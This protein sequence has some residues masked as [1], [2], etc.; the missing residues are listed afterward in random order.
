MTL[1]GADAG[2]FDQP[3]APDGVQFDV[4]DIVQNSA[5]IRATRPRRFH[6]KNRLVTAT[7]VIN[8]QYADF[9]SAVAAAVAEVSKYDQLGTV[10]FS[11]GTTTLTLYQ[12]TV[13]ARGG[14]QG[15]QCRWAY[16][17]QGTLSA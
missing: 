17:V 4:Q 10:T 15:A 1:A 9:P 16:T 2:C 13:T 6:R 8:R 3:E 14:T 7:F 5:V 11:D 12:A